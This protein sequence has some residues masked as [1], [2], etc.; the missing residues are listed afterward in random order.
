M[1]PFSRVKEALKLVEQDIDNF[2]EE[3]RSQLKKTWMNWNNL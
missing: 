1:I 3:E 2:K